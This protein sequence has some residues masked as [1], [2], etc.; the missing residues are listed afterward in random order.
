MRSPVRSQSCTYTV[1]DASEYCA[2]VAMDCI[3]PGVDLSQPSGASTMMTSHTVPLKP[4]DSVENDTELE[5]NTGK[6][7]THRVIHMRIYR[8]AASLCS[9]LGAK[10]K[11]IS[12][13]WRATRKESIRA[14]E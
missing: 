1:V 2:A 13:G 4:S 9:E 3:L 5:K 7:Q 6:K 8:S 12:T 10:E 14:S 11:D